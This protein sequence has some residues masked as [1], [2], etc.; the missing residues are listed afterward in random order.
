MATTLT[1][2]TLSLMGAACVADTRDGSSYGDGSLVTPTASRAAATPETK[3]SPTSLPGSTPQPTSTGNGSQLQGFAYPIAG[4]CLPKGDQ[5]MPNARRDYRLGIH[6]GVDFYDVDNCTMIGLGTPVH[7]AKAGVVIRVDTNYQSP[8]VQQM[9]AWLA[10]PTADASFDGFRGR[11]VWVDHGG[12]IVTRYCHLSKVT[13][14][15][16]VGAAVKQ[17][18]V[19]A[20]VGESGTPESV[21]NPGNQYHLHFELR[22]GG[23]YLGAGES[24]AKVRLLYTT[25]FGQ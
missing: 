1:L 4:G 22:V 12:G 24:P 10:D 18:D 16:A 5:L 15:L 8:T 14:G 3:A 13:D 20:F 7:A 25:L 23:S 6:E 2:L 17:G 19:I 11:Q 21:S 9:N